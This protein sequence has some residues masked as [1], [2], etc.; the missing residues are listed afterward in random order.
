V[1]IKSEWV[2]NIKRS[3]NF[4]DWIRLTQKRVSWRTVTAG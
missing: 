3:W 2:D 4:M 1:N